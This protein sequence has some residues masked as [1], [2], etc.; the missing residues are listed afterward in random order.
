MLFRQLFRSLMLRLLPS[1]TVKHSN[2]SNILR[3]VFILELSFS[4][5][6]GVDDRLHVSSADW[7]DILLS[8]A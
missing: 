1:D 3:V 4:K 7:R 6:G 2:L 8:L 5:S